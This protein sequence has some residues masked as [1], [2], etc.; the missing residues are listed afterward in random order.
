MT[1]EIPERM[2][3][4]VQRR[5]RDLR[6]GERVVPE[7]AAG[8]VLV[9]VQANGI[10]GSGLHTWREMMYGPGIVMGHEIAGEV[11][12][13]G[14]GVKQVPQGDADRLLEHVRPGG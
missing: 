8:E 3:A 14:A 4:V 12:A 5:P 7:P 2:R 9:R 11:V 6:V 13:L 10:C 1:A